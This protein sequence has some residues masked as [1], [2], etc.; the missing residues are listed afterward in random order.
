MKLKE[1]ENGKIIIEQIGNSIY[2]RFYELTSWGS[3]E[4][5]RYMDV[6]SIINAS[7]FISISEK[8]ANVGIDVRNMMQKPFIESW[9]Y[10]GISFTRE[11]S[12]Y[13]DPHPRHDI[14]IN[15][16]TFLYYPIGGDQLDIERY[17]LNMWNFHVPNYQKGHVY[18]R[19][20]YGG[21]I[22]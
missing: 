21:V 13:W 18:V 1:S 9:D 2:V 7:E 5:R 8:I 14:K 19:I 4:T 17:S 12:P 20:V 11:L 6:T 10:N 3:D 22:L 16:Y 15:E